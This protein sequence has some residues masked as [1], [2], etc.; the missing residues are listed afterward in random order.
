M[1]T[2]IARYSW[3]RRRKSDGFFVVLEFIIQLIF[4]QFLVFELFVLKFFVLFI[5]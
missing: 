5:L 4:L 2:V 1:L 3:L